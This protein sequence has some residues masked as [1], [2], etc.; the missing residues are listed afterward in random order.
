MARRSLDGS[1][2]I[3]TGA[4]GGIGR[5]LARALTLEG[6]RLVLLARRGDRLAALAAEL[7]A[8]GRTAEVVVGD[9]TDPLVRRQTIAAAADRLG[10]LD[11]LINNAGVGAIGPFESAA[12]ER[13]RRVMEVD[14]FALAEMIREALPLLKL[15][16]QPMVA[17]IGSILGR[18]ALPRS[19]EYCAAKFAVRGFTEAL[20]LELAPAGIEFLLVSPATTETEFL[21]NLIEE[22]GQAAWRATKATPAAKVAR[23]IVRGIRRGSREVFPDLNSRLVYWM[24][25]VSPGLLNYV[26][27]RR[28]G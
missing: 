13:L 19:S 25:R 17:N 4:S 23:A 11:L 1:R 14:F 7:A 2:A 18:I 10:G 12:P 6:A 26:L 5:E 16:R 21:E 9:V 28:L 24:T 22:Q 3:V 8:A 15:G 27:A 20:R